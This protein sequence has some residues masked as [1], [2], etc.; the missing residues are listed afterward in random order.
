VSMPFGGT[1]AVGERVRRMKRANIKRDQA[2]L[3]IGMIRRG[4]PE[5]LF[6]ELFND[7]WKKQITANWIDAVAREFSEMIAP[8]PAVNCSSRAMKTNAD[9]AKAAKKNVIGSHY[10]RESNLKAHMVSWVDGYLSYGFAAFSV[11]P[12]YQCSMPKIRAEDGIGAYYEND[13]DGNTL[14][15]AKCY[16]ETVDKLAALFPQYEHV[17]RNKRDQ[18]GNERAAGGDETLE[19]V[20][21]RDA[22]GD[23]MFLPDRADQV[24]SYVPN[25]TGKLLV[26]VAERPGLFHGEVEGA[27]DQ[28]I[29]VQLA[30]HRMALLSLEAGVKS[31]GAPLAV[32]RDVVEL[33]V[34]SDAVI[35]TE[36]PEK[37]RRV[38]LEVPQGAFALQELLESELRMGGR[39]PEGRAGGLDASVITG[40]GVQALMGSFDSQ[41]QTHQTVVGAALAK[42]I[43]FAFELDV[44]VW[45]NTAKRITGSSSGEAYDLT[46][47]P[48]K[49]VGD[50]FAVDVTYG[51]GA[52]LAPNAAVV[53]M[54]QLRGD[55]LID[56][57]TVRKNLPFDIDDERMQ[58]SLD[59][60]AT[61]DALKQGLFG[62]LQ[63]LGPL[64][65]QGQDPRP[66]LRAAAEIIKG[67]QNGKQLEQL[68]IDAFAPDVMTDPEQA[69]K[70]Q[71]ANAAMQQ[72]GPGASVDNGGQALPGQDP[73]S[74]LP[75]GTVPGQAGMAPG[76]APDLQTLV[77]GMRGGRPQ[78][79]AAVTRRLP[80]A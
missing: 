48:A 26:R 39:Y 76:G 7:T 75:A 27:F 3:Q 34:G 64:A 50:N 20:L 42:A 13:R 5:L 51:F 23:T 80:T 47:T 2:M 60:E 22:A 53:M 18:W 6:P 49:D 9:K 73:N 38:A 41:I 11:E 52:G 62:L 56:R 43:E 40:R 46:Y 30:R 24:L 8:L 78:L 57:S 61:S 12:D 32:P 19:V 28:V 17:I 25:P 65:A 33:A 58:R 1:S 45:P 31:V 29:W 63:G 14:R 72:G 77:A 79:D 4:R 54:L 21:Y 74:G 36:S 59:V 44:K 10:L 66:F 71:A 16:L 70:D 68:F 15:Y 69:A 55:G 37:V 35:Q 67:R